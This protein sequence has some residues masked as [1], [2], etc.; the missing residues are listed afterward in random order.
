MQQVRSSTPA[1][2]EAAPGAAPA[3]GGQQRSPARTVLPALLMAGVL[4]VLVR[5]ASFPLS[6]FDTYFH[7]RFGHE[8]LTGSWSLR[9]PG[10]VSSFA[11]ADWVPTQWLPQ[12]VMAQTEEWFGLPGVA[13]LSGLFFLSLAV[14]V[15]WA[16]R[17]QAEPTS[18]RCWSSSRWSPARRACRC[19][20]SRSAT[21]WCSSPPPCGSGPGTP[22]ARRGSWSH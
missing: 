13:W 10:S 20:R 16:C 12:V 3:E 14:T 7:L 19:G 6:N 18:P 21:S 9:H 8:F 17:R 2:P 11:T 15:Y 22:D 5:V 4:V 1:D